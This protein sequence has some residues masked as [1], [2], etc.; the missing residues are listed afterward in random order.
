MVSNQFNQ[1]YG[2]ITNGGLNGF[3][4]KYVRVGVLMEGSEGKK[5]KVIWGILGKNWII[6]NWYRLSIVIKQIAMEMELMIVK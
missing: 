5:M 2:I 3:V 1:I 6:W 4:G